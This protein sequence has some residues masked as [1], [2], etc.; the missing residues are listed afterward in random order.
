MTLQPEAG[1]TE[2]F[3]KNV[4]LPAGM[5]LILNPDN[6]VLYAAPYNRAG[7][8]GDFELAVLKAGQLYSLSG[9]PGPYVSV[10]EWMFE[11]V[12]RIFFQEAPEYV[13]VALPPDM[14]A[15]GG[16][17]ASTEEGVSLY[18]VSRTEAKRLEGI[19][20][21]RAPPRPSTVF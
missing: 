14:T 3:K 13:T 2:T 1:S 19:L 21:D 7:L 9:R 11:G 5:A 8:S 4:C 15:P 10:R 16:P 12:G 17:Q 20:D 18:R 6:V